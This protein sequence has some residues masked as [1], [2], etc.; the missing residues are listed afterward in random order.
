VLATSHAYPDRQVELHFLRCDVG[1]AP[2]PQLGQEMKW[3]AREELA[4][5]IFPPA[6]AELIQMLVGTK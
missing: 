4:T 3:V 1:G 2:A 5:L 6:D